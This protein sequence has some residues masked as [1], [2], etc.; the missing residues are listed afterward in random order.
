MAFMI[1]FDLL[2]AIYGPRCPGGVDFSVVLPTQEDEIAVGVQFPF[3]E[4]RVATWSLRALRDDVRNLANDLVFRFC[5]KR[6]SATRI[7]TAA[8]ALTPEQF[9]GLIPV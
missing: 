7:G 3:A 5:N 6:I 1:G 9:D 4:S 2:E 8:G